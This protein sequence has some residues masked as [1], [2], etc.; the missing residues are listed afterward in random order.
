MGR[1]R[2]DRSPTSTEEAAGAQPDGQDKLNTIRRTLRI[3]ETICTEKS[4]LTAS[5]L[6][7]MHGVSAPLMHSYIRSILKEGWIFRDRDT[8]KVYPTVKILGIG[9][10]V[11]SNNEVTEICHPTLSDLCRELR[12]T[13]HLAVREGDLG[14][15]VDKV[16]HSEAIPSITRIGMSFDL[17][18]TALRKA[19]LAFLSREEIESYLSRIELIPYTRN[20]IVDKGDLLRE[21]EKIRKNG[22]SV[23]NAEHRL[24]L[25]AIGVPIFDYS[26]QV[27]ASISI[28]PP[29]SADQSA[30]VRLFEKIRP[31]VAGLSEKLGHTLRGEAVVG[32]LPGGRT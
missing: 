15:C 30:I 23:D 16:G 12:S 29:Y 32:S 18:A 11:A 13:I 28:L 25:R 22:Y 4:G 9:S 2:V 8:R 20:T 10:H 26:N 1:K 17:Y 7:K 3:I 24:D 27:I 5:E 14:V 19:I 21:L 31:A 6:A